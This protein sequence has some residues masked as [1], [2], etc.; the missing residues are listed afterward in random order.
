MENRERFEAHI[1][2]HH[3]IECTVCDAI[4]ITGKDLKEHMSEEHGYECDICN[5]KCK[6]EEKLKKHMC[7]VTIK[8]PTFKDLYIKDWIVPATCISIFSS[9]HKRQR[10]ILHSQECVKIN[11]CSE[12]PVWYPSEDANFDGCIWHLECENF[13]VNGTIN[14]ELLDFK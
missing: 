9:R 3:Q 7:R 14:W 1:K 10:A 6:N 13:E 2:T 12:L 5:Y 8:N 4:F 11:K